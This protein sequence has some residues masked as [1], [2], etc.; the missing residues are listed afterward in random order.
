LLEVAKCADAN[1]RRLGELL[2]GQSRCPPTIPDKR[3]EPIG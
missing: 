3:P 1:R 2:L